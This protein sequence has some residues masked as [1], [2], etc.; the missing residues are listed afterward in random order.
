MTPTYWDVTINEIYAE[1]FVRYKNLLL[2]RPDLQKTLHIILCANISKFKMYANHF[3]P[4]LYK[5]D[6]VQL[7][8]CM[9]INISRY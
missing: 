6:I 4:Y 8:R 2:G 3:E 7:R 1:K 5:A 9:K